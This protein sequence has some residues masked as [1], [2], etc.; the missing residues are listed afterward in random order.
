MDGIWGCLDEDVGEDGEG[1]AGANDGLD[2]LEGFEEAFFGDLK[3]H[4]G[5]G[6]NCWCEFC[7]P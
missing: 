2:F 7:N 3:F 1:G 6:S 5:D 4:G